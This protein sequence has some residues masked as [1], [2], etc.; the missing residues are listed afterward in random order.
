MG[1]V[2]GSPDADAQHAE[3]VDRVRG[4]IDAAGGEAFKLIADL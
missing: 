4:E 2:E 3:F 1:I